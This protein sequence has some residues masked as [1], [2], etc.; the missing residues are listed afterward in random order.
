MNTYASRTTKENSD[1]SSLMAKVM[2]LLSGSLVISS[3]GSY[4]GLGITSGWVLL[5]LIRRA[6]CRHIWCS[7]PSR[8]LTSPWRSRPSNLDIYQWLS[9]WPCCK[10]V[11][12]HHWRQTV[13]FSFMGTAAIMA[14]LGCWELS[15]DAI[16]RLGQ[17]A[18]HRLT[19]TNY[20][21]ASSACS[22][23]LAIHLICSIHWQVW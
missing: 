15:P 19:R 17:M 6:H 16:Q 23:A 20:C 14:V 18:F 22:Q 7:C 5:G 3:I 21:P 11:C 10:H 8:Y 13:T 12:C 4:M 1:S 2:M 9:H